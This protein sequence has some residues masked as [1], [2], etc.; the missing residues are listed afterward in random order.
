MH[1]IRIYR[2]GRGL[3][4]TFKGPNAEKLAREAYP[5][6]NEFLWLR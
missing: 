1:T 6:D 2:R 4:A 5:E 3:V